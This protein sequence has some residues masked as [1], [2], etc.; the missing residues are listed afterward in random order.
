VRLRSTATGRPVSPR[1]SFT[2]SL[3][4]RRGARSFQTGRSWSKRGEQDNV[5]GARGGSGFAHGFVEG[6]ADWS[7]TTPRSCD[8][9]L[10][11]AEPMV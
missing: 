6:V 3:K 9:I 7:G 10:A 2:S 8:S 11:A 5:A 4:T 1:H